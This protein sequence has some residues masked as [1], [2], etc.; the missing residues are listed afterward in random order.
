MFIHHPSDSISLGPY[1]MQRLVLLLNFIY[2]NTST[3]KSADSFSSTDNKTHDDI[4]RKLKR[5]ICDKYKTLTFILTPGL[6]FHSAV[7]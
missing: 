7:N 3:F 4:Q 6:L 5:K 1:C 2:W